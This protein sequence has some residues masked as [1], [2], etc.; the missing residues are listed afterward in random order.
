MGAPFSVNITFL[1]ESADFPC[2]ILMVYLKL[3]FRYCSLSVYLVFSS[4][5]IHPS[6]LPP[7]TPNA[8]AASNAFTIIPVVRVKGSFM[9][10]RRPPL[11]LL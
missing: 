3:I 2:P 8:P 4:S 9:H 11:A 5:K 6:W 7:R 10:F 1:I